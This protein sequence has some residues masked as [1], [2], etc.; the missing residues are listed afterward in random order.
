MFVFLF[1][2]FISL[3]FILQSNIIIL[4]YNLSDFFV[5]RLGLQNYDQDRFEA[6]RSFI[7][8]LENAPLF[9]RGPGNYEQLS[10]RYAA[11]SLYFRTLGKKRILDYSF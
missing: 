5:S 9:G 7:K 3:L 4:G 10:E 8:V 11:H 2:V 6:R 1:V